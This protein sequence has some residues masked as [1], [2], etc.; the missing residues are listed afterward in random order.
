MEDVFTKARKGASAPLGLQSPGRLLI[1]RGS[2][3]GRKT[4]HRLWLWASLF[5]LVVLTRPPRSETHTTCSI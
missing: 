5:R 4:E 3:D 2:A 1:R